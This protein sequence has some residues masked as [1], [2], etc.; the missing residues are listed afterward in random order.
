MTTLSHTPID[1]RRAYFL[2]LLTTLCWGGNA[3]IGRAAVGEVSPMLLVCLRWLGVVL[4]LFVFAHH[5]VRRDWPALRRNAGYVITMGALGFTCFNA[6]FY[7]AAHYTSAVNIG[8]LQGAIP[9]IV[10]VGAFVCYQTPVRL[11]QV[12]GVLLTLLG[13]IMVAA[14]GD[15]TR[16]LE[17]AFNHGDLLMLVACLLYAGYTLGLRR[18][19]LD[20]SSLGLFIGFATSAFVVS[21]PFVAIEYVLG[22]LQWPT[23]MGWSMIALATLFPSFVA[24]IAFMKSVETIGPGRAGVFVNLVPIFAA[25]MAVI[26]LQEAFYSYHAIA[27]ALVLGGIALAELAKPH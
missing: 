22:E 27:L 20:L 14:G 21:L 3:I 25:I 8:I 7:T 19:P 17:L 2:L 15:M 5:L 13:V 24:Q 23:L 6:L 16:L 4:L 18:K 9:V 26:F 1:P 11:L 12:V 10:L